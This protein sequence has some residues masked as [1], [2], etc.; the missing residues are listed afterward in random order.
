[1][2]KSNDDKNQKN[3]IETSAVNKICKDASEVVKSL[4][5]THDEQLMNKESLAQV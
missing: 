1:M 2:P 4:V 5:C 3:M